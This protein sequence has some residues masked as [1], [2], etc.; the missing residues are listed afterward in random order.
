MR[1]LSRAN[2]GTLAFTYDGEIYTLASAA[3]A[4]P[5]QVKVSITAD[6]PDEKTTL[7]ATRGARGAKVSPDGKQVAFTYRGD[8]YVTSVDY[9]TTKQITDTPGAESE[10]VWGNDST[11]YYT[12]DRDGLYNI[13]RATFAKSADEPDFTHATVVSEEPVFKA[14]S[15]ER[16]VPEVS[17]D[18]KQL[19]F[20]LDRTNLCVMNLKSKAVKQLT[21]KATHAQR[22]GGFDY[23]WSPDSRWIALEVVDKKHDPYT[24]IAIINVDNGQMTNITNSGYFDESPRWILDGN[25]LA[26]ASERYG[27]RNHAS[28]GSMSDVFFVFMNQDAYDRFTLSKEE[29]EIYDKKAEQAKKDAKKDEKESDKKDKKNK[30]EVEP[31]NV[32]LA[33]ISDRQ[34]R[35]TPMSTELSDAVLD[36][37]GK[38]LYFISNAPDGAFI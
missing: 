19:G 24:D 36:A 10:V 6:Y 20:I 21:T 4:K 22:T 17:P 7:T 12:S 23:F 5:A 28:W 30:D 34:V 16:T 26:F 29:R 13:Y 38:T 8:V 3:G 18:G 27:M 33:G 9:A 32:E 31:I 15:H 37:D 1:F 14:D 25:A 11:L 35:I 2:D